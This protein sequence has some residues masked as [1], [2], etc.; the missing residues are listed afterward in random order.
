MTHEVTNQPPPLAGYDVYTADLVL[1]EAVNRE[2]GAG[3]TSALSELGR[4]AGDQTW[5]DSGFRANEHPPRLRTHDRYGH[6]ID[7]VDYHPAWHQLMDVAVRHGLHGGP[8]RDPGPGAHVARAAGHLVWSQVEAGV[9][10]PITMTYASIA[11]LRGTPELAKVWEPVITA[12]VYQ[13]ELLPIQAKTGALIGMAMTEKQG[14]SD[15][16]ANTTTAVSSG[17]DGEYRLTGHKWFCSAPMSDAFLVLARTESGPT[18]FLLP[19]VLPDGT[20]N[21]IRL[22]RLKDKLGNRANASSE[23]ELDGAFAWRL[24]EP[25]RGIATIASM[26]NLTRLDCILGSAALIRQ[27]SAQA[28][29]HGRH[30]QAFG[31]RLADQP[32]MG[33]VLADLAVESEAATALAIRLAG[34]V[35]RSEQ[36]TGPGAGS[37]DA[38]H[39][40]ARS[41]AAHSGAQSGAAHSGVDREHELLIRRIG[42]AV[43]KFWVCKRGPQVTAEALECLGGNGYVEE[44]IMPRLYREAPVNSVWEGSGNVNVLDV[45]RVLT[46]EPNTAHALLAELDRAGG[47]DTRLDAHVQLL[48]GALAALP[49]AM[50]DDPAAVQRDGRRLV[51]AMALAL[52]G[53]LLVRHS[54]AAVADAFCGSRLAPEAA[55]WTFGSAGA[56]TDSGTKTILERHLPL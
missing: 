1:T 36:A 50:K 32:L 43:G 38:D 10:C 16:R 29:H 34:A 17:P 21:S 11:A 9:A 19:R 30:R 44:S 15:L 47:G 25:G 48:R 3:A 5:I 56:A 12:P 14:G 35:D 41:D 51:T 46:R 55:G 28:L 7:E 39:P 31:A 42:T 45:L 8:W 13:P 20:R 24:A 52:Q 54:P 23:I 49:T 37:A 18:C 2:G 33:V 53:A 40:G 26:V 6:R 27:A 4:L 22:Q